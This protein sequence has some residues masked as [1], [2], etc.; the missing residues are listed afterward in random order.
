MKV[1]YLSIGL[2]LSFN[3]FA[4]SSYVCSYGDSMRVIEVVYDTPGQAVPCRV[5]YTKAMGSQFLWSAQSQEG[6]CEQKAKEFT[7]KQEAYG[8]QCVEMVDELDLKKVPELVIN[9][10]E[11][12][13]QAESE[14]LQIEKNTA[15]E[16]DSFDLDNFPEEEQN[17]E[18]FNE[19]EVES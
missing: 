16:F 17:D 6:Y 12:I 10:P 11:Q 19:L 2:F 3:L 13:E 18:L 1:I 9:K 15:P 8:W 5:K 4:Q 14:H 7:N